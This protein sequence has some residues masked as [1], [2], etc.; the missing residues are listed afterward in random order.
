M[1]G[2]TWPRK[3]GHGLGLAGFAENMARLAHTPLLLCMAKRQLMR[4]QQMLFIAVPGRSSHSEGQPK[5]L[6]KRLL[7]DGLPALLT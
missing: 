2:M 4:L 1:F 7:G 6:L 5:G 3:A